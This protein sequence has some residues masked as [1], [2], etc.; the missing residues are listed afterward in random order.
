M[1]KLLIIAMI[2]SSPA[3][4]F[5]QT[6]NVGVNGL[7][8]SFCAVAIEK[9]FAKKNIDDVEVN[10]GEKYVRFELEDQQLSD[11]EITKLINDAGY[12]V[13]EIERDE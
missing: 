6:V 8:C 7:V 11:E 5:S 12:D 10:L 13:T 4:A 2:I 3:A 1:K 9:T